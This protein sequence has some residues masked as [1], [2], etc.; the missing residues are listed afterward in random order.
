MWSLLRMWSLTTSCS[1]LSAWV[2]PVIDR[3]LMTTWHHTHHQQHQQQYENATVYENPTSAYRTHNIFDLSVFSASSTASSAFPTNFFSSSTTTNKGSQLSSVHDAYQQHPFDSTLPAINSG[4]RYD[5][6]SPSSAPLPPSS[7]TN[8]PPSSFHPAHAHLTR[9]TRSPA[10]RSRPRLR[11]PSSSSAPFPPLSAAN[12]S[13]GM[14]PARTTRARRN[15][16]IPGIS[17]PPFGVHH[18]HGRPHVIVIPGSRMAR[19]VGWRG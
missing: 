15:D 19:L 1:R 5:P 6:P 18:G 14:G 16:S 17:P 3:R 4:M 13:G 10:S 8:L 11:P 9:H 12:G 2:D 7:T